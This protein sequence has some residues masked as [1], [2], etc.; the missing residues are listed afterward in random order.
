MF[1][2]VVFSATFLASV[3]NASAAA[4]ALNPFKL[5]F[6]GNVALTTDYRFRGLAQSQNDPAIQAS[7]SFSHDSGVYFG[8]FA[9]NVHFSGDTPHL[10]LS[11]YIGYS[12]EL[13]LSPRIKP[14]LDVGYTR[15]NYPSW[16]DWAWDEFAIRLT[17]ADVLFSGDSLL[18]NVNYGIDYA[19]F[20]GNEWNFTLAYASP[21][22]D[23][24][25]GIVSSVGYSRIADKGALAEADADA[26]LDWKIGMSYGFKSI[27]GLTAELSAVGTDLDTDGLADVVQRSVEPG[28]VFTLSKTF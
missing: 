12:T 8:V 3:S 22:A 14:V 10:E 16:S 26:Y 21:I 19:G 24:G 6:S 9:S 28:A 15:F 1:K 17:F 2:K 7:F 20:A 13:D 23:S 5:N 25:F 18:T 4:E 11:P 27:P